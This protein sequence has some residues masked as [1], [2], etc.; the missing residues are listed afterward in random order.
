MA[1]SFCLILY[2]LRF[3]TLTSF[4]TQRLN[5]GMT[6][7]SGATRVIAAKQS[8]EIALNII[9]KYKQKRRKKMNIVQY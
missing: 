2:F 7:N 1:L 4:I 3:C 9:Y 8:E 5:S 6:A